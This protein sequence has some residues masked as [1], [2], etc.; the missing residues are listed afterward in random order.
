M[1][2]L[3]LGACGGGGGDA[4]PIDELEARAAEALCNFEIRCEVAPD[5]AG[6]EETFYFRQQLVADVKS[7]KIIYDG[8]AAAACLSLYPTLT[9]AVSD[10]GLSSVGHAQSCRNA[11]KGTVAAG[12]SCLIGEECLSQSCQKA[13]CNGAIECCAGTCLATIPA[14]GDCSNM[15]GRCA[16]DL[17]CRR[18][19]DATGVCTATIADGQPCT[20]T[21][22]CVSGRRCNLVPGTNAGTCGVLPARGQAC[23]ADL[24][25]SLTDVCDPT[26]KT[27]VGLIALGGDCSAIPTGCVPYARCDA[28]TKTC[29]TRKRAGEA[30]TQTT[31][32]LSGVACTGGVCV[33]PADKPVCP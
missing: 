28:A 33:P 18:N 13:G 7:G 4:I 29:V 8:R 27:C 1:A 6:C 16:D 10:P 11:I 20:S 22:L 2:L 26:S 32:C 21:D 19:P 5:R 25:D 24:C 9:C 14:G 17:F 30:C 12:G 31:D 3:W 15:T 23:P